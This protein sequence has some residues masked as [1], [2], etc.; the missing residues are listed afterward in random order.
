MTAAWPTNMPAKMNSPH[1]AVPQNFQIRGGRTM[2]AA[3]G[4]GLS[5]LSESIN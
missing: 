5:G 3:R 1:S 4:G 2:D